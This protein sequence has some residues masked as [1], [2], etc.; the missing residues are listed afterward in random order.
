MGLQQAPDEERGEMTIRLPYRTVAGLGLVG[1]LA[2]FTAPE[3]RADGDAGHPDFTF[4]GAPVSG[5]T[6][7]GDATELTPDAAYVDQFVHDEVLH[8]RIPREMEGSTLHVSL[9]T[10]HDGSEDM[11]AYSMELSTWEGEDCAS[12][13]DSGMVMETGERLRTS[14][15]ATG[16]AAGEEAAGLDED[17]GDLCGEADELVLSIGEDWEEDDMGDRPFELLVYEEP[18]NEEAEEMAE[19]PDY[20]DLDWTEMGRDISGSITAEPGSDFTDVPSVEAGSTYDTTISPGEVQIFS[21]P[22]TWG[23]HLQAEAYFPDTGV[24]DSVDSVALA[25]LDPL[26]GLHD[27][28]YESPSF[29][30]TT[31]LRTASDPVNWSNRYDSWSSSALA[32]EYYLVVTADE[33]GS[34]EDEDA[35][36]DYLLTVQ[37]YD[38]EDDTAAPAYAG[39]LTDAQPPFG[40]QN[41]VAAAEAAEEEERAQMTALERVRSMG[42]STGLVMSMGA[43][44]LLL[45]ATGS[46]FMVRAIRQH[47]RNNPPRY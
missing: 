20:S 39:G 36:L 12:T 19:E 35:D 7:L 14:H 42:E 1:L 16:R 11:D 30:D 13:T 6:H 43:F 9:T 21:I 31:E 45:M 22:L 8:Y 34:D 3:A 46:L 40:P 25:V 17:E 10:A 27:G 23:E 38:W 28:E 29:G 37:T 4:G 18:L 44:A 15:I 5:G 24:V 47:Q 33:A 41:A 26:R 2:A 32:G